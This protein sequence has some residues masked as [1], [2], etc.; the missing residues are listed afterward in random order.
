MVSEGTTASAFGE[1]FILDKPEIYILDKPK[2]KQSV[3]K[4]G[5]RTN[6]DEIFIP[7]EPVRKQPVRTNKNRKESGKKSMKFGKL[8]EHK[9]A[10]FLQGHAKES[11][12][13][14]DVI[15]PIGFDPDNLNLTDL[16]DLILGEIEV[17]VKSEKKKNG[18]FTL[19][20]RINVDDFTNYVEIVDENLK[21]ACE[22]PRPKGRGFLLRDITLRSQNF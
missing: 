5:K 14:G 12:T 2:K 19:A 3:K 4:R 20:N 21:T 16:K 9:V 10:K 17:S 7:D 22:L 8:I 15:L 18:M 13:K 1:L 6:F 11:L